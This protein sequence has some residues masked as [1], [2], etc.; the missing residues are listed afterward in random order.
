MPQLV[1]AHTVRVSEHAHQRLREL[2]ANQEE[3]MGALIERA[4]ERLYREEFLAAANAAWE[5]ILEDPQAR[6]E[7]AAEQALW[8]QT[9]A[10]GLEEPW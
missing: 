8:D 5:A 2:S 7:I 4:I 9:I 6:E 3:P 10:D 1:K